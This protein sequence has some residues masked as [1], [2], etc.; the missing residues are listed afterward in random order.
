MKKQI[1]IGIAN[2]FENI[3]QEKLRHQFQSKKVYDKYMANIDVDD[4]YGKAISAVQ[5][6]WDQNYVMSEE[7][8]KAFVKSCK[9]KQ[10]DMSRHKLGFI[11]FLPIKQEYEFIK[12]DWADEMSQRF[13]SE[14]TTSEDH[15]IFEDRSISAYSSHHYAELWGSKKQKFHGWISDYIVD[16]VLQIWHHLFH[17]ISPEI[18]CMN[19]MVPN[20]FVTTDKTA[21]KSAINSIRR[22]TN[23]K[24]FEGI[25][26]FLVPICHGMHYYLCVINLAKNEGYVIDGMNFDGCYRSNKKEYMQRALALIIL[27]QKLDNKI[28]EF[29]SNIPTTFGLKDFKLKS[30]FVPEQT[31]GSMCGVI[32]LMAVYQIY[33]QGKSI[34]RMYSPSNTEKFRELFY[35]TIFTSVVSLLKKAK[36]I[37]HEAK[38]EKMKNKE[39]NKKKDE[40]DTEEHT[41][42]DTSKLE[43]QPIHKQEHEKGSNT[44]KQTIGTSNLETPPIHKQEQEETKQ[45]KGAN[46]KEQEEMNQEKGANTKEQS[47]GTSNLETPPIHKQEQEVTNQEKGA[48]TEEQ[49]I[50]TSNLETQPIQ[51][52]KKTQ[53]IQNETET[54]TNKEETDDKQIKSEIQQNRNEKPEVQRSDS[55]MEVETKTD[56]KE[57]EASEQEPSSKENS[58]NLLENEKSE[59]SKMNESKTHEKE[60]E[61]TQTTDKEATEKE[62]KDS[63]E[64]FNQETQPPTDQNENSTQP[65]NQNSNKKVNRETQPPTDQ[66]ENSTQPTNQNTETQLTD[67]NE[68]STPD[69][70]ENE[71]TPT[72]KENKESEETNEKDIVVNSDEKDSSVN[73][74]TQPTDQ[75][76]N[77]ITPTEK[78]NKESEETN[79]KDIV[80]NS[81]E[82]D[83]SVNQETQ[84]TDQN[85]NAI[86]PTENKNRESEETNEA[87]E[88]NVVDS[89][90]K[91]NLAKPQQRDIASTDGTITSSDATI[92]IQKPDVSKSKADDAIADKAESNTSSQSVD[93]QKKSD[94][95]KSSGKTPLQVLSEL[96]SNMEEM[97]DQNISSENNDDDETLTDDPNDETNSF[98]DTIVSKDAQN[99]LPP[100][101]KPTL[102]QIHYPE[103]QPLDTLYSNVEYP[104]AQ[105]LDTF[106]GND[107]LVD[108]SDEEYLETDNENQSETI[109]QDT[110]P[111]TNPLTKPSSD[112]G[113]LAKFN[114]MLEERRKNPKRLRVSFSE[115]TLSPNKGIRRQPVPKSPRTRNMT[116]TPRKNL[117]QKKRKKKQKRKKRRR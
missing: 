99:Q 45:E 61:Q 116:K 95:S 110:N 66:N 106:T 79:E 40:T 101:P 29:K 4:L 115:N 19:S 71:I 60:E 104:E 87:D 103:S 57:E 114:K 11:Q 113:K 81:D 30:C 63:N 47:I 80:V 74:E 35:H 89:D 26:M 21:I 67:Q 58:P 6:H 107:G 105:P 7:E 48:N 102:S 41:P 65:T 9:N 55:P 32:A 59:I 27:C 51:K 37:E 91:D 1:L 18:L 5:K 75:N 10:Q 83:S 98:P 93:V 3:D 17:E 54:N 70:N 72:G 117:Q 13:F 97:K 46:T 8:K 25:D 64:T 112:G 82:K 23:D 14:N 31:D 22:L 16:H 50:G 76:E 56:E 42:M 52:E 73:Q 36:E 77:V 38:K 39:R 24:L 100:L 68:N 111:Q 86:S 85:E 34:K 2:K 94:A 53:P 28:T 96:S 44:E 49:T 90:E 20:L 33:I 62:N 109:V 15:E 92:T 108:S 12:E 88:K 43:T 69:Q 78:E 84:P